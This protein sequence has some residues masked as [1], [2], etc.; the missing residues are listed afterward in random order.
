MKF[1]CEKCGKTEEQISLPYQWAEIYQ[2]SAD[3]HD[4]DIVMHKKEYYLCPDCRIV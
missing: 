4:S 2:R 3:V 1:K